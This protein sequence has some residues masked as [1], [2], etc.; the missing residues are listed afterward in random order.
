MA[1]PS[2]RAEP[3]PLNL[4]SSYIMNSTL[5]KAEQRSRIGQQKKFCCTLCYHK[6]K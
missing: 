2:G 6:T 3:E 4:Y 1:M 5:G